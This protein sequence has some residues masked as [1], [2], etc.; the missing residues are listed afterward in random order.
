MGPQSGN[1]RTRLEGAV[2]AG[3]SITSYPEGTQVLVLEEGAVD[4]S[5][6][7]RADSLYLAAVSN[8]SNYMRSLAMDAVTADAS[9]KITIGSDN[10]AEVKAQGSY[11]RN[12]MQYNTSSPRFSC[13]TGTQKSIVIYA[14][15]PRTTVAQV[16]GDADGSGNVDVADV[17]LI[18]SI[19]LGEA[20]MVD[21]ADVDG[22]GNIDVADVTFVVSRILGTSEE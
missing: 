7:F 18:I 4:G 3:D 12:V 10:A 15:S 19:I 17:T 5:F 14:K 6:A 13:Y 8:S 21:T 1:F 20:E 16:V 11:T 22:S 2:I 9:W